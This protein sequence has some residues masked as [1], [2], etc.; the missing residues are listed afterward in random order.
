MAKVICQQINGKSGNT[1]RNYLIKGNDSTDGF[2]AWNPATTLADLT[3]DVR[4]LAWEG[5]TLKNWNGTTWAS[6]SGGGG[7]TSWDGLYAS[8]KAL[9]IDGASLAFNGTHATND[10]FTLT[11]ATGSGATL[12]ITTS[13]T[14]ADVNG[15]S[16]T[17][18][19]S[20]AGA[21]VFTAVTGC[22]T[23]TAAANLAI[24]ATAAGTIDIGDVSTG[25]VTITPALVAVASVTITGSADTDVLTIT[26]GDALV[27]DGQLTITESD[28]ATYALNITSSGTG[29]GGVKVTADDLTSGS[30]IYGDSDNGASFSG[31]G[32][33]LNFI[34]GTSSV[35]KVQRYGALTIAG[36]AEG[37]ASITC[38]KGDV[39]LS[40]GALVITAGAF[41]YTAGDMAMSDGSLSITD[42]DNAAT[43]SVTNNTATSAAVIV[44]AGSGVRTGS[45]TSSFMT[46]TPSGM[47]TGTG[48]YGVFAGLTE[49]KGVH[50]VTDATAT[51]GS[52][53]YVENAGNDCALTSGTVATF[54]HTAAVLASAVNKTG[55]V[56]SIS[57]ARTVNTGGSTADDFDTLSVIKAT[58]RTAG[59][60]G[61]TGSAIYAEVQT[62]GTVTETSNGIEIVMDSGG[63]GNA[64]KATHSATGAVALAVSS[65][66]TTV[67]DVTF[68]GSGIKETT[69]SVVAITNGTAA[70]KAGS[71][72]L[73]VASGASTPAAATSYL[74]EFTYAASTMTN[75]PIT[76]SVN[77][78]AS[79]APALNITGSGAGTTVVDANGYSLATYNTNDTAVGVK[80]LAQHTSTGS[81]ADNDVIFTFNM[82]GLDNADATN[83]YASMVATAIDVTAAT[84]DGKL[85]FQ[86]SV[87]G[88]LT[89]M[90]YLQSST[91][92][93]TTLVTAAAAMTL[94]GSAAGTTALTVTNGDIS[95]SAGGFDSTTTD[96]FYGLDVTVN[97]AAATQ[98]VA[99]FTNASTT[100]AKHVLEIEQADVDEPY[101]KFSGST[102][103]TSATA[104]ANGDVPAQVVGYLLVDIDGT[105][106]KIP[107]Y[108][109]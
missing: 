68:T 1:A 78:G 85:D 109:S 49:G 48:V 21:A 81:A 42:A 65:A 34:N 35:F 103:V 104:G 69:K 59:T 89:S 94:A 15:T 10:V 91:A 13:G 57:S 44:L 73:R 107:Y 33:Y 29:G 83:I 99:V 100:S 6:F 56:V 24:N 50:L 40:D 37:T 63:T 47:T 98:G 72:L 2:V 87:G 82:V 97:K 54:V 38:T 84:E 95:L 45:T 22:D 108:A 18:N 26:D 71:S 74:A 70:N 9:T 61:T 67:S 64:L 102:A 55:A 106:R 25:S 30:L 5:T 53:L 28:T 93:A 105:D 90:L 23:L 31:D 3:S 4:A 101:M 32:G 51:T 77:S 8:D 62:T 12:Q 86:I 60:A 46:I 16:D 17:W 58:T 11:N 20:K 96:D 27:D 66:S 39:V 92:G 41:T 75:N 76:I 19:V 88:T 52:A 80:W 14:G 79:T 36:N 43:F 7:I